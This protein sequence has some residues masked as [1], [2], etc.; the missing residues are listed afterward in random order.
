MF[1]EAAWFQ[2]TFQRGVT[3]FR[4]RA[5]RPSSA[6]QFCF[7]RFPMNESPMF[8]APLCSLMCF[9]KCPQEHGRPFCGDSEEFFLGIENGNTTADLKICLLEICY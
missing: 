1:L 9:H 2:R 3:V 8:G 4:E 5:V 7:G 6:S